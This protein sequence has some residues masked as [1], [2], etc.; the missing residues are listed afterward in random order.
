MPF[1]RC[2]LSNNLKLMKPSYLYIL[3]HVDVRTLFF[4][5]RENKSNK[6][7][8]FAGCCWFINVSDIVRLLV[9]LCRCLVSLLVC[10]VAV[11]S[12]DRPSAIRSFV[13]SLARFAGRS[14]G[15]SVG[16]GSLVGASFVSY[17]HIFHIYNIIIICQ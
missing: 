8:L 2:I 11:C 5:I 10:R 1:S 3:G 4:K 9:K 13:R 17:L 15:G 6:N 16:R 12:I 14:F 7:I